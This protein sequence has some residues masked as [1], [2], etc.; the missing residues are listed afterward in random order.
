M[1]NAMAQDDLVFPYNLDANPCPVDL[2][3]HDA[4]KPELQGKMFAYKRVCVA[5]P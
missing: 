3:L 1:Q 2:M 5:Q 4:W